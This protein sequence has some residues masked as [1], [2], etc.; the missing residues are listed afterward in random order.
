MKDLLQ[1]ERCAEMLAALAAPERLRIIRFL[2]DGARNVT[3]IAEMLHVP[4]VN[5]AHHL[6][7]LRDAGLLQRLK[8]GR[9]VVYSL[10]PDILQAATAATDHL[11]LGCCRL[12]LPAPE[13]S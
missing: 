9:F 8:Q 1:P 13:P 11:D 10:T 6:A 4:P 7:K 12:E 2:R 3:E 5:A